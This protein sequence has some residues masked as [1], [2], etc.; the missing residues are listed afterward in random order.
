MASNRNRTAGNN[1]ERKVVNELKEL[2]FEDVVTSRAESR[3]MDNAGVDIFGKDL[4]YHIQCKNSKTWQNLHELITSDKLP[5]DKPLV[6]FQR[7][8]RKA[9]TRF[10]TEGDY[11]SMSKETTC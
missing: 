3:N 10:V 6:V 4:P 1:F 9:N 2:G 11:V 7:K 5:E 8:T